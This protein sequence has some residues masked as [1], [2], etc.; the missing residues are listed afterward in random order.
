[1]TPASAEIVGWISLGVCLA[2]SL[3]IV[4][5]EFVLGHRQQMAIMN[6]VHPVTALYL[7]PVWLWAYFTRGRRSSR[8]VMAARAGA[9]AR[10]G[11]DPDRL[12]REGRSVAPEDM[13]AWHVGNAV[14]HCGA[15]CALGDIAGEWIVFAFGLAVAGVGTFGP[16]LALDFPIAWLLGVGFQYFTIVPMRDDVSPARGLLLAMRADTL[17]IVSSQL[18]L[19]GWM[20]LSHFVIWQPSL[21][22]DSSAHWWMMQVGMVVGYG[23]AWPV[24]LLLVKKGWKEKMDHRSHLGMLVERAEEA[25]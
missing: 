25:A 9:L 22:I 2:C 18:G 10:R 5:D 16:E 11:A 24:N 17:S 15:G 7:G 1:M 3:V 13:S 12:E 19:F 6:V 21:P 8:K 23:T 4:V 20:A 14:S